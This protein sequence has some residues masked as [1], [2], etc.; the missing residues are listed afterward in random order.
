MT[1]ENRI[2]QNVTRSI[3][4]MEFTKRNAPEIL[5]V[6]LDQ[7]GLETLLYYQREVPRGPEFLNDWLNLAPSTTREGMYLRPEMYH[8]NDYGNG[9]YSITM[10][11]PPHIDHN[12][13]IKNPKVI[14][15]IDHGVT[16][17]TWMIHKSALEGTVFEDPAFREYKSEK[18]RSRLKEIAAFEDLKTGKPVVHSFDPLSEYYDTPATD[19]KPTVGN[20]KQQNIAQI[21]KE[22]GVKYLSSPLNL[23]PEHLPMLEQMEK[24][25]QKL[26]KE[27]FGAKEDDKIDI[28][29]HL[30]YPPSTTG[31][32]MHAR[33]N[34]ALHPFEE[35]NVIKL[36]TVKKTLQNGQSIWDMLLN[37]R[38]CYLKDR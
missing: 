12:Q 23:T 14:K 36:E 24:S 18:L 32:H 30:F 11:N 10:P 17:I 6:T 19:T 16:C 9:Y 22:T 29:F 28:Y 37:K 33:L 7:K 1:K 26:L 25:A 27:E 38:E 13:M 35:A 3:A 34:Q 31:L 5:D 8:F 20:L 4:P 21:E 2:N 15:E